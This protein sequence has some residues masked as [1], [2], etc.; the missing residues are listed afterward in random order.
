MTRRILLIGVPIAA[1][2]A[3]AGLY[4]TRRTRP[5]AID[6]EGESLVYRDGWIEAR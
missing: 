1:L 6:P 5:L 2:A 4:A 3:L